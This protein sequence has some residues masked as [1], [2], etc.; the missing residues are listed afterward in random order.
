MTKVDDPAEALGL[1]EGALNISSVQDAGLALDRRRAHAQVGFYAMEDLLAVLRLKFFG[2]MGNKAPGG[3]RDFCWSFFAFFL[4]LFRFPGGDRILTVANGPESIARKSVALVPAG[5]RIREPIRVWGEAAGPAKSETF[6]ELRS[7]ELRDAFVMENWSYQSAVVDQSLVIARREDQ[8]E[9]RLGGAGDTRYP[10]GIM[11]NRQ[12]VAWAKVQS[13]GKAIERAAYVGTRSPQTWA[14]WLINFLPSLYLLTS[15]GS[16]LDDLPILVP[17]SIPQDPHWHQSLQVVLGNRRTIPLRRDE[18]TL[19]RELHWID[20]PFYDTPFASNPTSRAS[21][22]LHLEFMLDFRK[23]Y[24]KE[25]G[26]QHLEGDLPGRFFLA[27]GTGSKRPYNQKEAIELAKRFGIEPVYVET[28]S[29][30]QKVQLFHEASVIVGP[31]GS[32]LAN[33]IFSAP[34]TQV[35]TWWPDRT[36]PTDNYLFNLAAASGARYATAP[37][38]WTTPMNPQDG[39]YTI[40]LDSLESAISSL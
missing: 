23:T 10:T 34:N 38:H 30:W 25:L 2:F 21:T 36:S 33:V 4:R 20:A 14:H 5:T 27:R 22:S 26:K 8:G 29:F 13:H 40:D 24:L 15:R 19:V 6:P 35:L 11:G 7:H 32:G 1:D 9:W 37:S 17:S 39:S 16:G 28:L 31:E 18:F 12:G 3:L